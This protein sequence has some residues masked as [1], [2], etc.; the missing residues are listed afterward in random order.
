[1][2]NLFVLAALSFLSHNLFAALQIEGNLGGEYGNPAPGYGSYEEMPGEATC[3]EESIITPE[4]SKVVCVGWELKDAEGTVIRSSDSLAEGESKTKII[5]TGNDTSATILTWKFKKGFF[6]KT[7]AQGNGQLLEDKS[8]WYSEGDTV[9]VSIN[10]SFRCN[11]KGWGGFTSSD[12]HNYMDPFL[13]KVKAA[14]TL[15][16]YFTTS[17]RDELVLN[18][19]FEM[20]RNPNE[21]YSVAWDDA[22]DITPN[23]NKLSAGTWHGL[24][25]G[26]KNMYIQT[27]LLR[28]RTNNRSQISAYGNNGLSCIF[29][30]YLYAGGDANGV[31]S[32]SCYVNIPCPG[33]YGFSFVCA[34]GKV[35]SGNYLLTGTWK[36]EF[37]LINELDNTK[38]IKIYPEGD[39]DWNEDGLTQVGSN[40]ADL[41]WVEKGCEVKIRDPGI[42]K[43]TIRIDGKK[44]DGS[45]SYTRVMGSYAAWAFDNVSLKLRRRFG[46]SLRIR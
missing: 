29:M 1:M 19:D 35:D 36:V 33:D 30:P 18:G 46:F 21:L 24:I 40:E 27:G 26:G 10:E 9:E 32:I 43:L 14:A 41:V 38:K 15:C 12:T 25:K 17:D 6:I 23:L 34:A 39:S 3:E 37:D 16:A 28:K 2:K 42:Y 45:R 44:D 20:N 4:E 13:H 11:F 31:S 22:T 8:G 5:F 7:I